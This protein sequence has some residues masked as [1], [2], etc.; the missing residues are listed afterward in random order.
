MGQAKIK[1]RA[2]FAPQLIDEW[3]AEGCVNFAVALARLTGWLLHVDWWTPS[4][5]Q[6]ED[7]PIDRLKP[8]RVYVADNH[9]L[10]F[11]VRGVKSLFDF[12]EGTLAPL[13][14]KFGNGGVRT[15]FY[16]ETK[17]SSLPLGNQPDEAKIARAMEAIKAN[18]YYL[19][20]I[21]ARQP[22][23]IPAHKAALFTYGRCAAFAEAMHELIGLQ[24]TALL[25]VRFLPQFEGTRRTESG[26]FHS[27]VLH[28]DGMAEDAWGKAPLKE[29]AKRFGVLEFKTD[30]D[31]HHHVVKN[32]K[33]N[34]PDAYA[35]AHQEAV[36]V[37]QRHRLLAAK[38]PMP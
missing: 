8:L 9:D 27:A 2:A 32:L 7:I 15:R 33:S 23:Y 25:A 37:V 17:L 16:D 26:Y 10:I 18:T 11:D 3:E 1:Q 19:A 4:M 35:A 20:A 34:S 24:P 6:M 28:P 30:N 13:A 38:P 22:P 31:G 14:R 5:N 36:D 12:N 29:I 21:P